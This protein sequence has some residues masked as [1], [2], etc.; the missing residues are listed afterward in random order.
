MTSVRRPSA[1]TVRQGPVLARRPAL[2]PIAATV[3]AWAALVAVLPPSSWT[4]LGQP[5]GVPGEP[6]LG[7]HPGHGSIF[8]LAGMAM[9]ALMTVAMMAP[10]A[11]PGV[12]TIAAISA[13]W[14]TGRASSWFFAAFIATWTVLAVC[15]APVVE[16]L[17]GV[18]GSATLAAGI[19]TAVCALAEFDPRRSQLTRACEPLRLRGGS[20][21]NSDWARF[22]VL[23][24]GRGVRLCA[25]PMLAMLTAPASLPVMAVLTVLSVADRAT[26]GARRLPIAA[27]YLVLAAVLLVV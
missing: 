5:P 17:A 16:L 13:W 2:L 1:R 19:L 3:L 15:L 24:A 26:D 21:V 11:I 18:L 25:L 14:R 9:L 22:G 8:T 12:R 6:L 4:S 7:T 10:M 27:G 23:T 20:M